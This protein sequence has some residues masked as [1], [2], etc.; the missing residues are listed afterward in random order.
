M[1]KSELEV[2]KAVAILN[3]NDRRGIDPLTQESGETHLRMVGHADPLLSLIYEK[4]LVP[5]FSNNERDEY[6]AINT[7]LADNDANL[8]KKIQFYVVAALKN[9][10]LIGTTIFSFMGCNHFCLMS[11]Q[12]TTVVPEERGQYIGRAL[13]NYRVKIA[14]TAARQFGYRTLDLSIVTLTEPQNGSREFCSPSS[15]DL[16]TL[17]KI[18]RSLGYQ[19]I[20][21][22][23][24][25]LPLADEKSSSQAL[26]CIKRHSSQ[27]SRRNFL[28]K[29]EMKYIIDACN[30]FRISKKPNASYPEYQLMMDVL[31]KHSQIRIS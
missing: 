1:S 25:Q 9:N 10:T 15:L 23:F 6:Q 29:E 28:T 20:D 4:L 11:G 5:F 18:W 22:P 14:Q 17:Q 30:Y 12:Y 16:I 31:E 19:R 7:Y 24:I 21:F 8:K 2:A 26:I 13:N 3:P 27:Y